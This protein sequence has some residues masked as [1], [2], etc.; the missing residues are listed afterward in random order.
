MPN[1]LGFSQKSYITGFV[2]WLNL[3]ADLCEVVVAFGAKVLVSLLIFYRDSLQS[4]SHTE[5]KSSFALAL[6]AFV[7]SS[8]R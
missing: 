7:S 6:A 8:W 1:C 5:L 2:H 4:Y 3:M